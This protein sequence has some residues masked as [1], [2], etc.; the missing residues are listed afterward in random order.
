MNYGSKENTSAKNREFSRITTFLPLAAR[1]ISLEEWEASRPKLFGDAI[2]SEHSTLPEIDDARL[3]IWLKTIN[4]KL[5]AMMNIIT[6]SQAG[7]DSLVP[8]YATISASGMAFL[9]AEDIPVDACMEIK[10]LLF[11][12]SPVAVKIYGKV[13]TVKKQNNQYKIAIKFSPMDDHIRD[14]IVRFVF[15]RER[16]FLRE[17]KGE[18]GY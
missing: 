16:E 10:I 7:F 6:L 13:L 4:A 5:D 1:V 18:K 2:Y 14:E 17:K 3:S 15:E 9:F 8:H 12:L 11:S